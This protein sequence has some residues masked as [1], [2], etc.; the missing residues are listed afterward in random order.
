MVMVKCNLL[1]NRLLRALRHIILEVLLQGWVTEKC[2]KK[3]RLI[4]HSSIFK[5]CVT[6]ENLLNVPL[7]VL[8]S[9]PPCGRNVFVLYV[10]TIR[11]P[12][13]S[14]RNYLQN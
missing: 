13:E 2:K 1:M 5:I 9:L 7:P 8:L 10:N 12:T 3:K 4:L 6:H 14:V 11:D